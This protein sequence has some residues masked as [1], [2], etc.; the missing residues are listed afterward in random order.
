MKPSIAI[1]DDQLSNA[2]NGLG[3][4]FIMGGKNQDQPLHKHPAELIAALAKSQEARLR[5][6]L[7]P[8]ILQLILQRQEFLSQVHAMS[9]SPFNKRRLSLSPKDQKPVFYAKNKDKLFMDY[10]KEPLIVSLKEFIKSEV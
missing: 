6:S 2:L 8:L 7:I 5:L 10:W 9:P 4:R 3:V 1:S